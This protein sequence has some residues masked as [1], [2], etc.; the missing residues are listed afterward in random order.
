M[1]DYPCEYYKNMFSSSIK[2]YKV[3]EISTYTDGNIINS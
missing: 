2:L 3:L 1:S